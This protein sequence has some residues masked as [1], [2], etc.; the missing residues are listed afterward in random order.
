MNRNMKASSPLPKCFL[1]IALTVL[2]VLISCEKKQQSLNQD[3]IQTSV[4]TATALTTSQPTGI[5]TSA[6]T[7]MPS[8]PPRPTPTDMVL[9][10]IWEETRYIKEG[11]EQTENSYITPR[12]SVTV[13]TVKEKKSQLN[14]GRFL[15]YH[16]ADIYI[17]D[18][19]SIRKGYSKDSF[20]SS[21]WKI[22]KMHSFF[23]AVITV[24]GDYVSSK[25]K[26]VIITNGELIHASKNFDRDLCVLYKDGTLECYAPEEIDVESILAKDPWQS[27]N[28][29]PILLDRYGELVEQYNTPASISGRNPRA[30]FGYYSP[31][32]YCFVVVDGR[33]DGHSAGLSLKEL[34]KLMKQLGCKQAYNLDGGITA[35]MAFNGKRIN[36]VNKERGLKDVIYIFDPSKSEYEEP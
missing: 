19:T 23:D 9:S 3:A 31:G 22:T 36:R 17:K 2:S 1:F 5:P 26:G 33:L 12:I 29:G 20:G 28:F 14:G 32:H 13:S 18:I 35:Q 6:P 34:S 10:S 15:C 4:P 8:L 30:V 16:I 25:R 27:W 21:A 11:I 7:P 24:S